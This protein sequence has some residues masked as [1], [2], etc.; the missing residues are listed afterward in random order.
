MPTIVTQKKFD[1]VTA[2]PGIAR[3]YASTLAAMKGLS[4]DL[5]LASHASQFELHRKRKP[6]DAYNPAAFMNRTGYDKSIADLQRQY[7]QHLKK[8]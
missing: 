4:F 2:Y 5:W 1:E 7:N 3:D 8:Q 6:G